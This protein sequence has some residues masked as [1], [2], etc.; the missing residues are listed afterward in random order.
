M[1]ESMRGGKFSDFHLEISSRFEINLYTE[2]VS[3]YESHK[4]TVS[5]ALMQSSERKKELARL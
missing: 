5:A 2:Q 1:F 4:I 3:Y